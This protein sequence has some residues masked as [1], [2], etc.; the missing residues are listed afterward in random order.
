MALGFTT[1]ALKEALRLWPPLPQ[2]PRVCE[3]DGWA[4]GGVAVPRG[5][6]VEVNVFAAHRFAAAAAAAATAAAAAAA[7]AIVQAFL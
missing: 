4:V 3:R 7:A 2:L 1:A 6:V 5:A